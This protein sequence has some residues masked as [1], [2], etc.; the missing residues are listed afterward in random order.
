M[1]GPCYYPCWGNPL[2][3]RVLLVGP[4]GRECRCAVFEAGWL[5]NEITRF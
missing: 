2:S 5:W 4:L 3:R 1:F